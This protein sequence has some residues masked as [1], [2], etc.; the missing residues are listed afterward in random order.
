MMRPGSPNIDDDDD[1]DDDDIMTISVIRDNGQ[2]I[3]LANSGIVNM[4][5]DKIATSLIKRIWLIVIPRNCSAAN[6]N[7]SNRF[8]IRQCIIAVTHNGTPY[9]V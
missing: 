2:Q 4:I 3:S 1:D 9:I 8:V 5:I 7:R 6:F